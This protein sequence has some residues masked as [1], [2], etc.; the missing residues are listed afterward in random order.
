MTM[1]EIWRD[2]LGIGGVFT[3]YQVSNYGNVRAVRVKGL[4]THYRLLTPYQGIGSHKGEMHVNLQMGNGRARTFS[5]HRLVAEMF[6]PK[7]EGC[8][9]V[10]YKDGD[11]TNNRVDN[12]YWTTRVRKVYR[13]RCKAYLEKKIEEFLLIHKKDISMYGDCD[14]KT[15]AEFF[16]EAGKNYYR[17]RK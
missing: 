2:I 5:V 1:K 12:L 11:Y 4:D 8:A 10:K 3:T 16:F 17:R 15:A 14:V 9:T 13:E 6:L 7:P